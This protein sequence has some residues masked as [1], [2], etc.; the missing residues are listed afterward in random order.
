MS[1]KLDSAASSATRPAARPPTR[2]TRG[3]E[4][5]GLTID[6]WP[7]ADLLMSVLA[8]V[9]KPAHRALDARDGWRKRAAALDDGFLSKLDHYGRETWINLLGLPMDL[10][11]ARTGGGFVET[12]RTMPPEDLVRYLLGFYRRVLRRE[13]PAA[14][15]DAAIRGDRSAQREF[16]RTSFPDVGYLRETLRYILSKE[17][18]E[19]QIEFAALVGRWHDEVHGLGEAEFVRTAEA[20]MAAFRRTTGGL[21]LEQVVE[22]AATGLTFVPETGQTSVV[23][24]P[25]VAIRPLWT[26]NDHR[27]SNIFAFSAPSPDGGRIDPPAR[28]V[29]LGKAIGDETRLRILRE[30]ATAPATPPDLADRM[31]IPRTSLLHHLRILRDA[32][33]IAVQVHDSAYHQYHVRDEHF[34]EVERLLEDYLG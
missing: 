30:L 31:G 5:V 26:V 28:L 20:S 11:D 34:G 25:T 16:R 33:L 29:A 2:L 27:T 6:V 4:T 23:L 32:D 10:P 9:D 15:M 14:V 24:L 1:K 22:T 7:T 17:P 19:I 12:V 18:A 3:P 21:P 8:V 13:T